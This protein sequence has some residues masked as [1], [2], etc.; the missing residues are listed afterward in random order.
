MSRYS[1][2]AYLERLSSEQLEIFLRQCMLF[3]RW[4]QYDHVVPQIFELLKKRSYT[5]D[6]LILASW[7]AYLQKQEQE[8]KT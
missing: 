5:V 6:Q 1:L 8:K 2:Q 4:D 3:N 7:E